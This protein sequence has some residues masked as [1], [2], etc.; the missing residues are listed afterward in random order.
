MW[1]VSTGKMPVEEDA[2]GFSE[3]FDATAAA[4]HKFAE[5]DPLEG[6][7]VNEVVALREGEKCVEESRCSATLGDDL[8]ESVAILLFGAMAVKRELRG[9]KHDG[10]GGSEIVGGVG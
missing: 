1:T 10:D 7:F 5:I 6:H 4:Y 9:G 3:V 2:A 8:G